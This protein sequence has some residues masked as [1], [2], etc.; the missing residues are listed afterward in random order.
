MFYAFTLP[1]LR[2]GAMLLIL[3][4]LTNFFSNSVFGSEKQEVTTYSLSV[5]FPTFDAYLISAEDGC[6]K[7]FVVLY[8]QDGSTKIYAASGTVWVGDCPPG[9]ADPANGLDTVSDDCYQFIDTDT[10]PYFVDSIINNPIWIPLIQNELGS[11]SSFR[12]KASGTSNELSPIHLQKL[13]DLER[14][15]FLF[16]QNKMI[17]GTVKNQKFTNKVKIG[18][19]SMDGK[20]LEKKGFY[21]DEN[22][23][24]SIQ[25]EK[26]LAKGIYIVKSMDD[27]KIS[28]V[29][30]VD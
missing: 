9:S 4:T 2:K 30:F 11:C 13:S 18:V 1:S 27:T 19:Y 12:V 3:F 23:D 5:P 25:F 6:F 29:V 7:Y 10:D 24:L 17:K 20:L 14:N 21:P 16:S 26:S 22:G 28:R 15:T 8:W